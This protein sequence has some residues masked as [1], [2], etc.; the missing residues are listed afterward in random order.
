ML[1]NPNCNEKLQDI[2]KQ[3]QKNV[4]QH[5]IT[6]SITKEIKADIINKNKQ[7]LQNKL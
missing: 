6:L 5:S 3:K 1:Y 2:M 7:F 4:P